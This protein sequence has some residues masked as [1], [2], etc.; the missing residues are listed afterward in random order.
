VKTECFNLVD[1]PWLPVTLVP[2]FPDTAARGA[3]P[4]VSLREAFEFGDQIV[5][6]RC[7]AHERIA[8]M[9]LL[10]CIAQRALNGPETEED[11]QTCRA[12]LANDA[13]K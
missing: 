3:A 4:R 11:W 8:L 13:V 1:E 10:I 9:R 2:G 12:R 6:L 5:D 7:Y